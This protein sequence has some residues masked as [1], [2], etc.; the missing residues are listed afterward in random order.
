MDAVEII[1]AQRCQVSG[2][3]VVPVHLVVL[4]CEEFLRDDAS[5]GGEVLLGRSG[6]ITATRPGACC[7]NMAER[8]PCQ[9][10]HL[11]G[12]GMGSRYFSW[13][14]FCGG[15]EVA[16]T[17]MAETGCSGAR[18]GS[19]HCTSSDQAVSRGASCWVRLRL[20]LQL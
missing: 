5:L 6:R 1:V 14:H 2:H 10:S 19:C 4:I 11:D 7:G 15:G 18:G 17:S 12:A 3:R 13:A 9:C 16:S 8:T 20:Q